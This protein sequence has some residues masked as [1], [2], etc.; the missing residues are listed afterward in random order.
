MKKKAKKP[1]NTTTVAD[2]VGT[3]TTAELRERWTEDLTAAARGLDRATVKAFVAAYYRTQR[4]RIRLT[5][6]VNAFAKDGRPIKVVEFLA[7]EIEVV[8]RRFHKVLDIFSRHHPLGVWLRSIHGIGPVLAAGIIAYVDVSKARTPSSVWRYAGLSGPQTWGPGQ[9]RPFNA[10][11]KRLCY[12]IVRSM[13]MCAGHRD[14]VYGQWLKSFW[15]HE[16]HKN[17]T[18]QLSA[19]AQEKLRALLASKRWPLVDGQIPEQLKATLSPE[20]QHTVDCWIAGK[21]TKHHVMMRAYRKTAKL[22][23]S[24]VFAVAWKLEHKTDAPLPYAF[25]HLGHD[26]TQFIPPP[27]EELVQRISH[28]L[29]LPHEELWHELEELA[30]QKVVVE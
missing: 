14:C 19:V 16:E 17:E 15:S 25:K 5:N 1:H 10:D 4:D 24:H 9:K 7:R 20:M 8:E 29:E 13:H 26:L 11:F 3:A 27:N 18:G 22:F 23:L 30:G 28:A 2:E 21:L 6:Q 12:L